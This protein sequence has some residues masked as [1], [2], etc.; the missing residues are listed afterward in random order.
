MTTIVAVKVAMLLLDAEVVVLGNDTLVLLAVVVLVV[1]C[2][3]LSTL[4][5]LNF[6]TGLDNHFLKTPRFLEFS[7]LPPPSVNT[8]LES[9]AEK[10]MH[11]YENVKVVVEKQ[12]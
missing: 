5:W 2:N 7:R 3:V 10:K 1:P 4:L 8:A 6:R 9:V 12:C 11:K